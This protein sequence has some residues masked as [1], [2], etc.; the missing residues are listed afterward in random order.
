MTKFAVVTDSTAY[1]PPEYIKKH[2]ITVAPQVLIWD[3]ETFRDGVDIQPDEFYTRLKTAKSM[4]STSQVSPAHNAIH[5]SVACGPGIWKY[6][7]FLFHQNSL[8]LCNLLS[9][10]RK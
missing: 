8:G 4:P 10:A 7:V 6:W 1:I 9:R 5:F 2:N 3:N